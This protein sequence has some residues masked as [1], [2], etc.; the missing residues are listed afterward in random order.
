MDE[1]GIACR[2]NEFNHNRDV[3][4]LKLDPTVF[5]LGGNYSFESLIKTQARMFENSQLSISPFRRR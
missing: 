1:R 3:R 5:A 4:K 2:H